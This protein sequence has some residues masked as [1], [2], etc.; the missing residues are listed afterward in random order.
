MLYALSAGRLRQLIFGLHLVLVADA[1]A[2]VREEDATSAGFG[3]VVGEDDVGNVRLLMKHLLRVGGG[4]GG[5]GCVDCYCRQHLLLRLQSLAV[6]D[7]T[8][9][10][11]SLQHER[12]I[13]VQSD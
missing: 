1:G 2:R 3:S 5:D 4:G 12:L 10:D 11:G 7:A 9:A 8:V 6:V 13:M